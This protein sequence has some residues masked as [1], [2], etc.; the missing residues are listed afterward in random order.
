MQTVLQHPK[1]EGS[2]RRIEVRSK[3]I[4][5]LYTLFYLHPRNTCQ[6]SHVE[7]L[8]PL[9]SGTMS[10]E[11][12]KILSIFKLFE[13]TKCT[14]IASLLVRW[15]S[16]PDTPSS[17]ALEAVQSFDAGRMLRTCLQ[18]PQRMTISEDLQPLVEGEHIYNPLFV[19]L[20][21]ASMLS[22]G[23]PTSA[24]GWVQ[25]FRTN[26]VGVLLRALS[27]HSEEIR[28]VAL[29]QIHGLY[30]AIQVRF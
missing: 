28:D 29:A 15:S 20:L 21:F 27:A 12:C 17:T 22:E 13:R 10:E 18:Y 7:P 8:L 3:L 19:I 26:V 1:F 14:S 11:D 6:A 4:T 16:T 25:L 9:Y 30:A 23:I 5:V 24:P 2:S